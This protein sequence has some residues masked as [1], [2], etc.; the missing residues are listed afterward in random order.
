[1]ENKASPSTK[2]PSAHSGAWGWAVTV[3][4]GLDP[5]PNVEHLAVMTNGIL[6]WK[7]KKKAEVHIN[8]KLDAV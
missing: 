6:F 8:Y 1:M 3:A 7:K 4:Q 5:C 2:G